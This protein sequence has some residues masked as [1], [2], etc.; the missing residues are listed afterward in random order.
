MP[1]VRTGPGE[2][3]DTSYFNLAPFF[4][5]AKVGGIFV[6]AGIRRA[7]DERLR[8]KVA[9]ASAYNLLHCHGWR[10]LAPDKR[11]PQ[12]DV[13][14]QDAWKANSPTSCSKSTARGRAKG[15]SG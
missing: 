4:E 2:T 12:A 11:R 6:V 1:V 5:K 13:A 15:R 9:L 10:K 3:P 8:R 7:L 14:A